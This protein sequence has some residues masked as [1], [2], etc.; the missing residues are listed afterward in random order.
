MHLIQACDQGLPGAP[1]TAASHT[2]PLQ[3]VDSG[4]CHLLV[5]TLLDSLSRSLGSG[6]ACSFR[7]RRL[8]TLTV[9]QDVVSIAEWSGGHMANGGQRH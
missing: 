8:S 7:L 4:Q 6:Q 9:V 1:P 5:H 3:S 2:P